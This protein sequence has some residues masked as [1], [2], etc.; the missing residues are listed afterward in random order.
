VTPFD[1]GA[2][3]AVLGA[4]YP[5]ASVD[6]L[7]RA[8]AERPGV[9]AGGSLVGN[10]S[11]LQ[12]ADGRQ[13]DLIGP[14]G[15]Q[16]VGHSADPA[17]AG[18]WDANRIAAFFVSKGVAVAF[19][20]VQQWIG[21]WALWGWKDPAFF[22]YRMSH[23]QELV[24]A[25]LADPLP[26]DTGGDGL[27]LDDGPLTPVDESTDFFG[28]GSAPSMESIVGDALAPLD[29]SDAQLDNVAGQVSAFDP[30]ASSA[31]LDDGTLD[32]AA[33]VHDATT[34]A[35][36]GESI[37]DLGGATDGQ[38][39]GVDPNRGQYDEAPPPD[40]PVVDPGPPPDKA[41]PGEPG[42]PPPA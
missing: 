22:V 13:F 9:F 31:A 32:Q 28:F 38:R 42:G 39:A 24:D 21:Y 11:V 10:G 29:G 35:F 19:S 27:T 15:W 37:A 34:A 17:V 23:A 6:A 26:A 18:V 7:A 12:L 14:N 41:G 33:G 40:A 5:I 25:G 4:F 16:V 8:R 3:L 36:A 30:A 2:L 1:P 20:V